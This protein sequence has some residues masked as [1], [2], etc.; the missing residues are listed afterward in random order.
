MPAGW[1]A[2]RDEKKPAAPLVRQP[3]KAS[4]ARTSSEL[5]LLLL[6]V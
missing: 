4:I 5:L 1:R 2:T 3:S 6:A